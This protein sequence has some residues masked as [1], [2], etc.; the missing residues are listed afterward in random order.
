MNSGNGF[1]SSKGANAELATQTFILVALNIDA[2]VGMSIG[3]DKTSSLGL[4]GVG[5]DM[6]C[7]CIK[8]I[9]LDKMV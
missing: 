2:M 7:L 8:T 6:L 5:L 1:A 4:I 3:E 9:F